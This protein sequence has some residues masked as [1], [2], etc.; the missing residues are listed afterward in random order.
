M[1]HL[2][3]TATIAIITTIFASCAHTKY[4]T[5]PEVH[6]Q[7]ISRTDTFL[8]R[9]TFIDYNETIIRE[10]DSASLAAYGILLENQKKAYLIQNSKLQ[11]QLQEKQVILIDTVIKRD[12]IPYPVEVEKVVTHENYTGWILFFLLLGGIIYFKRK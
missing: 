6:T 12:S 11:K 5:V 8:Q 7:Y 3:W 2:V 10:V 4:V 1:T 9:D